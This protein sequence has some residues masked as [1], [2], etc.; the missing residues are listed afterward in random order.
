MQPVAADLLEVREA[1]EPAA[2]PLDPLGVLGVVDRIRLRDPDDVPAGHPLRL[3]QPQRRH[4]LPTEAD[5]LLVVG[6]PEVVAFEAEVLEPEA[7]AAG[8]RRHPGA[9]GGEV[10]DP[11]DPHPRVVDVDP[12]VREGR[13]ALDRQGD[14]EEVPVAQPGRRGGHLG[15]RRRFGHSDRGPQGDRGD[16]SGDLD[17]LPARS[18]PGQ[19]PVLVFEG[20]DRGAEADLAARALDPP[21]HLLPHLPRPQARVAELLDQA[22][23][24]L[25]TA[26][27][28]RA[29]GG[30]RREVGD[31]LGRPLGPQLV[32]PHPPDLFRIGLEEELE[33]AAAEA[34]SDPLL[35]ALLGAAPRQPGASIG[36]EAAGQLERADLGEDVARAQRVLDEATPPVD[37]REPWPDQQLLPQKLLPE[38]F[39]LLALGE[40]AVAAEVEAV[41]VAKDGAGEA[42]DLPL[43][44]EDDHRDVPLR[45]PVGGGEPGRTGPEDGDGSGIR[46]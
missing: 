43:G 28:G 27:K 33:E 1:V 14:G 15:G 39:D 44:L 20:F 7:G 24:R 5:Q 12:V 25:A 31:P 17:P 4:L 18:H 36:G 2:D 10:L 32:G 26:R 35:I 11:A 8:L 46:S 38:V 3:D 45:Q 6:R 37:P 23:R 9:P 41:A 21:R 22:L 34:R 42:A 40:E 30:D 13:L 29:Q 19:P 16:R